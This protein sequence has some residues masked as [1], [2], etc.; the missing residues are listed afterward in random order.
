MLRPRVTL[1]VVPPGTSVVALLLLLGYVSCSKTP[2]PAGAMPAP[3]SRPTRDANRIAELGRLRQILTPLHERPGAPQEGDWL[4][5][6][7]EDGETFEQWLA[8]KP[9]L[10]TAGRDRLYIQPIGPFSKTQRRILTLTADFM[11]RY[12]DLPVQV[13]PDL[14]LSVIPERAQREHPDQGMHQLH[15][16][17]ILDEVLLPRLPKDAAALLGLT[18]ID[19]YP[20][21]S[22]NFVFGE[23]YL[24]HRVGVWSM[25]RLGNPDTSAE[26]FRL[27]LLRTIGTA[28]HETGHMFG[29]QHCTLW[30]CNMA[31]SNNLEEADRG[32]LALCPECLPKLLWATG[33]NARRHLGRLAEFSR[34]HGMRDEGAFYER[35]LEALADGGQ[36]GTSVP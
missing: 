34:T 31:G 9:I 18:A 26:S 7:D 12:F 16:T 20:E 30:E 1:T 33:G 5:E 3:S 36:K 11:G 28:T 8:A 19:L 24:R 17:H 27:V 4:T 15:S 13:Q 35:Q 6:H 10:A 2:P 32:T 21:P 14:P 29:I 22:W 25:N 23:A